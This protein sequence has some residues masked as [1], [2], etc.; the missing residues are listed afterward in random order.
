MQQSRE[1]RQTATLKLSNQHFE[2]R[3]TFVQ[4]Q[5]RFAHGQ[6]WPSD[7]L[8]GLLA[9]LYGELQF[10]VVAPQLAEE[11][12]A[13]IVKGAAAVDETSEAKPH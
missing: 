9:D 2:K 5:E 8:T 3:S 12:P 1:R 4:P 6:S 10:A 11:P 13:E 7:P